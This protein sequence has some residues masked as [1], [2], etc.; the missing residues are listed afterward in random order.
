MRNDSIKWIAVVLVILILGV[1]VAAA[2]TQGFTNA[3]PYGWLDKKQAEPE[4]PADEEEAPSVENAYSILNVEEQGV[5]FTFGPLLAGEAVTASDPAY[6]TQTVTAVITPTTVED[7]FI[8]WTLAWAS[9]ASLS[10]KNISDYITL[11]DEAAQ[12]A[13]SITIYC[14]K[15]FRGS[16]IILT[17]KTRQGEKTATAT[18]KF[19]GVPSSLSINAISGAGSYNIGNQTLPMLYKGSSYT[20]TVAL[21]NIFHDAGSSFNDFTVSV[22]GVG[23][24]TC[25]DYSASP[26]GAYWKVNGYDP[27][28]K[29]MSEYANQ[30]LTLSI[31]G[32]TLSI[33]VDKSFYE[34][35]ESESTQY[36]EQIGNVTTYKNRVYSLNRDSNGN[37]PYLVITVT[38]R[39][40]GFSGTIKVFIGEQVNNV[41][42]S[43][44]SITF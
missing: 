44:T 26:R 9:G 8:N 16:N 24:M 28:T 29:N 15:S 23:T 25:Y 43:S 36:Q 42:L 35:R 5:T 17:A 30:F 19:E 2:L 12:G 11:S 10:N 41:T 39:T 21:D 20:T 7:Q 13:K 3:N 14:H 34:G 6:T 40:Y 18:I 32:N 22:S 33:T 4:E 31:S 1:A 37:L 38:H 27:V